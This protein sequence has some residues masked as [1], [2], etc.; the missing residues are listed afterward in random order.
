MSKSQYQ[1]VAAQSQSVFSAKEPRNTKFVFG[2]VVDYLLESLSRDKDQVVFVQVGAN[3]G[4]RGDALNKHI[5]EHDW[6]GLLI[7][8]VPAA[9]ERLS[10]TYRSIGSVDFAQTAIWTESG[11]K[12]F[13]IVDGA[14]VLS[15]F[16]R[17]TIMLHDLKY[18]DLA[19]MIR[20]VEVPTSRLDD[21]CRQ[22]G[23]ERPDVLAV[24]AEGCDDIVLGTFDFDL[25]RPSI[26]LFEHVALTHEA[27]SRLKELLEGLGYTLVYDRHDVLAIASGAFADHLTSFCQ[28][29]VMTARTN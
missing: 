25:H 18:D 20:E 5:R 16:S 27:S 11:T 8:P 19:S 15:S 28:D 10:E 29:I 1:G 3:D 21:L 2:L 12:P 14:D 26:V 22:R 13:Y 6:R 17:E 23:V 7:E 4:V 24:D 9:F